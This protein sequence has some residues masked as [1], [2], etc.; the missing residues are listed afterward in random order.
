[1]THEE[2]E[3]KVEAIF[4]KITPEEQEFIE[5][6]LDGAEIN[7]AINFVLIAFVL[8]TLFGGLGMMLIG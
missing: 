4:N 6:A 5:T 1:M 3:E 8:G 7:H 2:F